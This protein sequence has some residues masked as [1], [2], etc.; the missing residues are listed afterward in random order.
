MYT[1]IPFKIGAHF[2]YPNN[3]SVFIDLL[4]HM[5]IMPTHA[6]QYFLIII[7]SNKLWIVITLF[8]IDMAPNGIPF[9][10]KSIGK[11]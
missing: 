7:I 2:V 10:D 9:G 8:P 6:W 3:P 5:K 1:T 11:W 4:I